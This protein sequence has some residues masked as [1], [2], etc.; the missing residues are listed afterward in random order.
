MCRRQSDKSDHSSASASLG[1]VVLLPTSSATNV[2]HGHGRLESVR[3]PNI[4]SYLGTGPE[5]F[6]DLFCSSKQAGGHLSRPSS[7]HLMEDLFET[8]IFR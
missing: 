1:P 7:R 2:G 3:T 6:L 8:E 4:R 5:H